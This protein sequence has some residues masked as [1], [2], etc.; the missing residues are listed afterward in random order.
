MIGIYAL[1]WEQSDMVYIGQT[2]KENR[3]EQHIEQ[4]KKNTHF[5]YKC[6]EQYIKYGVPQ[7]HVLETCT[8]EELDKKE[9][10]W[11][12]EFDSNITGLNLT[13]GGVSGNGVSCSASVYTKKTIL[14]VFSMLYRTIATY[15]SISNRLNV[16]ISV[17]NKIAAGTEHIW[18]QE[19]YSEQFKQLREK[20]KLRST[21]NTPSRHKE[22]MYPEVVDS[23]GN[24]Y[25][26]VNAKEFCATHPKLGTAGYSNFSGVLRGVRKQHKGFKLLNPQVVTDNVIRPTLYGPNNE[27]YVGLTSLKEFCENNEYLM[28]TPNAN[29]GLSAVFR[30][31]RPLY[32]GFSLVR[33]GAES[34]QQNY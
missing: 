22:K 27:A 12:Q 29:K 8:I 11:I 1:Y 2:T 10:Q 3:Y 25:S 13:S 16:G 17:V 9:I 30:G 7:Y 21:E 19:Q 34:T 26:I 24:T 15:S 6:I 4:L 18:L 31:D 28:S 23:E 33:H 5:N 32:K 14:K 20:C